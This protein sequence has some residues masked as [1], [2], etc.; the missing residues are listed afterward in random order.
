MSKRT[1]PVKV[2]LS[3]YKER[4][5]DEG[6]VD[7]ELDDGSTF[8]IPPPELWPDSFAKGLKNEE[9]RNDAEAQARMIVGDD[10][11][12]RFIAGGGT[13]ML[14]HSLLKEEHGIEVGE[15][16]PSPDS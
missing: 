10:E 5:Q 6:A 8:R 1:G 11:F 14:F 13:T 12:D 2:K 9:F 15:S 3:D 4:K 7:V 16:E